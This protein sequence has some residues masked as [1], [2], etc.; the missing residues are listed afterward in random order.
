[1]SDDELLVA[2]QE[3]M[4]LLHWGLR[5][6]F[7]STFAYGNVGTEADLAHHLSSGNHLTPA[8]ADVVVATLNDALRGIGLP[9]PLQH[10]DSEV[11]AEQE[12]TS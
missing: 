6:L 8:Q 1:M 11:T 2:V 3:A 10:R 4:T 5:D 12:A 7:I 9:S